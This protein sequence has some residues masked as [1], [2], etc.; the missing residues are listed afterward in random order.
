[1]RGSNYNPNT[2][3]IF[4]EP[5]ASLYCRFHELA[6]KEQHESARWRILF[7]A[8]FVRGLTYLATLWLEYDAYRRARK[9]MEH[10]GVWSAEAETEA[11]LA[12][13]AY[14]RKESPPNVRPSLT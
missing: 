5:D 4:L 3:R 1:M 8:R 12:L 2:R 10:L 9:V 7:A 6:H 13:R 11:R 14:K